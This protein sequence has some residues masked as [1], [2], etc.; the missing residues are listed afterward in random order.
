M[1]LERNEVV[2]T[3][4]TVLEE[5]GLEGLTV[6]RIAS[7]LG[8]KPPVLYGHF[9]NRQDLLDQM[10]GAVF[11]EA[12]GEFD[13]AEQGVSWPDF[14]R[15]YG[16]WLRRVILRRR[17]G[18]KMVGGALAGGSLE[19]PMEFALRKFMAAGFSLRDAVR[20]VSTIY[21]YV[22]GCVVEEQAAGPRAAVEHPT[23]E[24]G[25]RMAASDRE[26]YPLAH[27]V[28]LELCQGY[29]ARFEAGLQIIVRGLKPDLHW[30]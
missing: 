20:A 7:E 1:A 23:G 21:C 11:A 26:R 12:V 10:A 6:R 14:A 27:G 22:V 5:V 24:G 18:A 13:P 19:G 28:G 9:K 30:N 17:D 8:V 3:A 25:P 29:D 16:R 4:L 2:R 15:G